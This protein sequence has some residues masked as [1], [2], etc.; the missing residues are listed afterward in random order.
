[1]RIPFKPFRPEIDENTALVRELHVYGQSVPI[2]SELKKAWQ[3]KGFGKK[4]L[5]KAEETV[6][7][8]FGIKKI[9]IISGVGAKPYYKK[10]GYKND[11]PFVSKV[12]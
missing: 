5:Q 3:H 7:N 6:K 1:L 4:L 8:E 11:G 10:F 9:I 12:L 2:G